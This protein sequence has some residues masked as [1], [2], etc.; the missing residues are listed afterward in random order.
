[1]IKKNPTIHQRVVCPAMFD[2]IST[3]IQ[4]FYPMVHAE[5]VRPGDVLR[6]VEATCKEAS[7][8]FTGNEMDLQ[9]LSVGG[10]AEM[11]TKHYRTISFGHLPL[12]WPRLAGW[13]Q[14][15]VM[16]NDRKVRKTQGPFSSF[17]KPDF[18]GWCP[19]TR[20]F[21]GN[22][23]LDLL[24]GNGL[25]CCGSYLPIQDLFKVYFYGSREFSQMLF[26]YEIN[27]YKIK[28]PSWPCQFRNLERE[29]KEVCALPRNLDLTNG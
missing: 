6:L 24:V 19:V 20:P 12:D 26:P 25:T 14:W 21:P 2:N 17:K 11:A 3:G 10:E 27:S 7:S 8:R 4:T 16:T 15:Y 29:G 22:L 1:M 13:Y 23:M 28:R 9:V 5:A 18:G